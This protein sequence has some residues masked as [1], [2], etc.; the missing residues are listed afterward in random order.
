MKK[1]SN[2]RGQSVLE[3]LVA[4]ASISVLLVGL[5]SLGIN[6]TKSTTYARNLNQATEYSGQAA[7][8]FRNLKH[9][10]GWAVLSDIVNEDTAGLTVIYCLNALPSTTND[11]RALQDEPCITGSYLSSTIFWREATLDLT[12]LGTGTIDVTIS[13]IWL[14]K[15]ERQATVELKLTQWN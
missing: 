13:S 10:M 1:K 8:W 3:I 11:F 9:E 4:T 5:L 12:N 15:T 7:D 14:D 2:S 6:S